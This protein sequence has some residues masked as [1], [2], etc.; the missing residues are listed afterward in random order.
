MDPVS[1]MMLGS[2]AIGVGMSLFGGVSAMSAQKQLSQYAQQNAQDE[3]QIDQQKRLQMELTAKR[4]GVENLRKSQQAMAANHAA[5]VAGGAQFGSG[6]AGG[7]SAAKQ[8]EAYN[9]LGISQNLAIG[10]NIFNLNQSI[11]QNK[12]TMAGLQGDVATDQG[13]SSLGSA[14][15]S[16]GKQF[17]QIMGPFGKNLFGG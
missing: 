11:D 1:M 4:Q 16:S 6:Y 5:A 7:Q 13:I 2:T 3:M 15:G 12:I 10:E 8:Q 14:I 9:A 17:G